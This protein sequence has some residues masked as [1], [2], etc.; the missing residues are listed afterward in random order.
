MALGGQFAMQV[1]APGGAIQQRRDWIE[2]F[3]L[4]IE[5]ERGLGTVDHHLRIGQ[6]EL[7]LADGQWQGIVASVEPAVSTDIAGA[8]TRR[9][10]HD[11]GVLRRAGVADK[12][13][14]DAPGWVARLALASDF[15]VIQ[16][17]VPDV[18]DGRS[19]IA[20]YPWF[21][22]WGR[23]TMI[24]LPGLCLATGRFDDA[25]KILE[26][27]A[28]YVDRGMLPN[29][30]PGAGDVPDYN[31]VD[32]ALWYVEAWRGYVATTGDT[33]ALTAAF[34]VLADII[35]WHLRGDPLRDR[36]RPVGR[37][38]ARRRARRAAYSG[39]THASAI[40]W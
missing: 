22:D 34:P 40:G 18:E 33:A 14:D 27:F 38:A 24:S 36:R 1:F 35:D 37:A 2:N 28:R 8:L 11:A 16:R 19:V 30:F 23:D 25:R 7:P 15:Y 32:A 9:R 26:T 20:G 10:E 12:A 39:W 29:V 6:V 5:R 3:D 31:T 13:F 21:G 17:P 4:P